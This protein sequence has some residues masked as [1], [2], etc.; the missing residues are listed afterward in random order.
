MC[1]NHTEMRKKKGI[2][3]ISVVHYPQKQLVWDKLFATER[4]KKIKMQGSAEN[5]IIIW[6]MI[7]FSTFSR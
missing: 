6:L 1:Q 3:P 5:N 7:I 2:N 4:K